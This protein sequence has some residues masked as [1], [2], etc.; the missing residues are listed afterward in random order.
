MR[1]KNKEEVDQRMYE[2]APEVPESMKEHHQYLMDRGLVPRSGALTHEAKS[3]DAIED[4]SV[5]AL[6]LTEEGRKSNGNK[7]W[8]IDE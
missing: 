3:S 6:Q 4:S 1:T 5:P 8:N 2:E 7:L